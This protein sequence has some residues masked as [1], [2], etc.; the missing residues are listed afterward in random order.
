MGL[1]PASSQGGGGG[2]GTVTS[3]T[4]ADTSIVVG[5]T[6]AAPTIATGTLDVIATDHAP[7]ASVPMNG[8]KLTGLA[9]GTGAGDSLRFEQLLAANVVPVASLVAG[10]AGQFLD[11]V[12]P[13]YITTALLPSTQ[14]AANPTGTTSA[15]KIMGGIGAT[16]KITPVWSGRI[17]FTIQGCLVP[18]TGNA[19]TFNLNTGIGSAPANGAATT[20]TPQLK[21]NFAGGGAIASENYPFC[22]VVEAA[23]FTLATQVWFD[24]AFSSSAGGTVGPASLTVSAVE[25]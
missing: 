15:T 25:F 17:R 7:V 18:A 20:G 11:P 6:A 9:A 21:D 2:G 23:G 24:I 14:I 5:G 13:A 4:A 16:A 10:A 22:M 12:G 8:H 1:S 3:V 19:V